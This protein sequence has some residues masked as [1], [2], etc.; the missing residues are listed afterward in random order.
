MRKSGVCVVLHDVLE[1]Q[2]RGL[3]NELWAR[4]MHIT[5]K[6]R[7]KHVA[8]KVALTG[9]SWHLVFATARSRKS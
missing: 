5:L 1:S 4:G 6:E 8:L 2:F 7:D 3:Q 9:W